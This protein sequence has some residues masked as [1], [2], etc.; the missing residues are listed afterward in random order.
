MEVLSLEGNQCFS[1]GAFT[2]AAK[3]PFGQSRVSK[4]A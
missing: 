2:K 1:H 3:F 4:S